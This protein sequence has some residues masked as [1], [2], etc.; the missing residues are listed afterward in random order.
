LLDGLCAELGL[1]FITRSEDNYLVN[2][3]KKRN[4]NNN[5]KIKGKVVISLRT[6]SR[7]AS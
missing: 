6:N 5:L 4:K 3:L 1:A 2:E 7:D